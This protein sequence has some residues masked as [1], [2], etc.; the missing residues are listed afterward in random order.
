MAVFN[1]KDK[2]RTSGGKA[3]NQ[4]RKHNKPPADQGGWGW[5]T[6][7]MLESPAFCS[8][9]P[10]ALKAVFR[11]VI[12][13]IGHGGLHNGKLIVT[14]AQFVAYGVTAEYVADALDELSFKGLVDIKRGRAGNGTS[15]PNQYRLTFTGDF[16]GAAPTNEWRKFTDEHAQHWRTS[17]RRQS[18][19]RR[20]KVGRKKKSPLRNSEIRPLRNSEIRRLAAGSLK[21]FPE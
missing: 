5:F 17:L 19:E 21:E 1:A 6:R 20:S 9:T 13:H 18:A 15:H 14:H 3:Y 11:I 4:V 8:L 10:N 7:E 12:E 2:S 16:E